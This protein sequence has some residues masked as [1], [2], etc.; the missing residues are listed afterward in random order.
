MNNSSKTKLFYLTLFILFCA[1]ASFAIYR[2]QLQP[3]PV[4]K[5]EPLAAPK[6]LR[7]EHYTPDITSFP[8]ATANPRKNVV[9]DRSPPT[10][11]DQMKA[12]KVDETKKNK[13]LALE[14]KIQRMNL[15]RQKSSQLKTMPVVI[16]MAKCPDGSVTGVLQ[17]ASVVTDEKNKTV[18]LDMRDDLGLPK[19]NL[20]SRKP[21]PCGP[22]PHGGEQRRAFI[23]F[24]ISK[25]PCPNDKFRFEVKV[26]SAYMSSV[27]LYGTSYFKPEI[28][29]KTELIA[30]CAKPSG[31]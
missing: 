25:E 17:L 2:W 29:M 23:Q 9:L 27:C 19:S 11:E 8:P 16:E 14:A 26:K 1:A 24:P 28:E 4:E 13:E 3:S 12:E 21:A 15:I 22:T 10:L 30:S 20:C 7:P 31:R 6:Q 5:T 18:A